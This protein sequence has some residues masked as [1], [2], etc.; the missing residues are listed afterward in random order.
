MAQQHLPDGRLVYLHCSSIF[1]GPNAQLRKAKKIS[2][3]LRNRKTSI[4]ILTDEFTLEAIAVIA[5]QLLDD[6][7]FE[8]LPRAKL[9]YP[10]L[11]QS[12]S[13]SQ[14]AERAASEA[15]VIRI[16]AEAA[17]D[18]LLTSDDDQDD[19]GLDLENDGHRLEAEDTVKY[20]A[21]GKT[22]E[23]NVLEPCQQ[24]TTQAQHLLSVPRL[25]P[26]YLPFRT[27]HRILV[28]V[29]ALLEQCCLDFGNTWVPDWMHAR[30]WHEAEAIELTE[31]TKRFLKCIKMLPSTAIKC[32]PGKSTG[33]VLFATSTLRHSAV[34]RLPTS[35]AGI[36]NMLDAAITFTDA[37]ND[38][39]RA[40]NIIKIRKQLEASIEEIVQHQNLL[41]RKLGDQLLDIARRRAELDELERLSIEEML[42]TDKHQR[43]EVSLVLEGFLGY[44]RLVPNPCACSHA[45][46]S[47]GARETSN[48][49][50]KLDNSCTGPKDSAEDR[51]A[52]SD[53]QSLHGESITHQKLEST[54]YD[55]RCCQD[56]GSGSDEEEPKVP[57]LTLSVSRSKRQKGNWKRTTVSGW[58]LPAP[59]E[60]QH[61]EVE[62]SD[63]ED[64]SFAAMNNS[65]NPESEDI[66]HEACRYV[67]SSV[68]AEGDAPPEAVSIDESCFTVPTGASF[69]T[70]HRTVTSEDG[71]LCDRTLPVEVADYKFHPIEAGQD[72]QVLAEV[73]KAEAMIEDIDSAEVTMPIPDT[74]TPCDDVWNPCEPISEPDIIPTES[75]LFKDGNSFASL[76]PPPPME[77]RSSS[78]PSSSL[79]PT[80]TKPGIPRIADPGEP[81]IESHTITLKICHSNKTYRSIVSIRDCT[82]TA[83]LHEGKKFC[84]QRARDE[85]NF[86][87]LLTTS[88]LLDLKSISMDGS[89]L[90]LT[91]YKVEDLSVLIKTIEKTDIPSFTLRI[92]EI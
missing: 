23:T 53:S 45:P 81:T 15:E 28:L 30:K 91:T 27:Q 43:S 13:E 33:E 68:A 56:D 67:A 76:S 40:E 47:D 44:S 74:D 42:A 11:F 51:E 83:I 77:D 62:A 10:E 66:E 55:R 65:H 46:S 75:A 57:N 21:E 29:Q 12:P 1:N 37:L 58:G 63:P 24:S 41:E 50:E 84:L 2:Q 4:K 5:K 22:I 26:V 17:Q 89:D 54:E 78:R 20:A 79:P 61:L 92:V 7:I 86:A 36:L 60:A 6:R 70:K 38:L 64:T 39:Q 25:H 32:I 73:P 82:R 18:T 71:S 14:E 72:D 85:P 31:W 9:R 59:E 35:A 87:E 3:L 69:V 8:S 34:H 48:T 19:E 49:E 88:W 80:S 52:P 90:D 16:E